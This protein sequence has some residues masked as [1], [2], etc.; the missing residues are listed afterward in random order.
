M[1]KV[2]DLVGGTPLV[3]IS[4]LS[5]LTGCNI[6]AKCEFLNPGGSIKDRAAKGIIADAESRGI[7]KPGATI[8]EGTAGNTGIGMATLAAERGYKVIVAMPDN[9]AAEK[10]ALLEALG[11]EVRRFQPVPFSNPAHFYHQAQRIAEE[12]GGFW[13]NQFENT[14][15]QEAHYT[16]TGRE[17][18]EQTQGRID[19]FVASVG[20][21]GTIAGVS[22]ALKEKNAK[23]Q[24]VLADPLG[25]GLY[26]YMQNGKLETEGSSVT[27]GIGIMRITANFSK[28]LVDSALRIGDQD[29]INTLFHVARHDGLFIGTSAALNLRAAYEIGMKNKDSGKVIVTVICDSGTRYQSKLL[30][31]AWRKEKNLEPLSFEAP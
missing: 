23:I 16:G 31:S 21:G 19:T 30:S 17:I 8:V 18:W 11:A 10:Y 20:S 24:V 3:E 9:Q 7:L 4:S 1:K 29:M 14:A 5:K 22:R 28:A 25:S 12:T 27:E 6:L 15:N 13:A 2:W 26:R